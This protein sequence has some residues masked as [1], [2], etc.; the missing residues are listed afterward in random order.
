M[1]RAEVESTYKIEDGII[2][3]PGKF[4]GEAVFVP[5]FWAGVLDGGEDD[6][7]GLYEDGDGLVSVIE[8]TDT[9]RAA[10]PELGITRILK[11]WEDDQGFVHSTAE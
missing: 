6:T 3:S 2:L 10:W 11:L 4:E 9:D 8:L 7:E 5:V 1:D